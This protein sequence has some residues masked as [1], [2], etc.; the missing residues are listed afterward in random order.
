MDFILGLLKALFRFSI[1]ILAIT[2]IFMPIRYLS[3]DYP[4]DR[5]VWAVLNRAQVSAE[6][7]DM[8]Q[9]VSKAIHG[10]ENREGLFSRK[11]Q[12]EGHCAAIFKTPEN[13]L[14]EQYRVLKNIR[15]RLDRTNQMDKM[16]VEYATSVD[17]IRGT[18]RELP[19]LSCWIWHWD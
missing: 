1:V 13:S 14:A 2:L 8:H 10:L 16:S 15:S 6:S 11:S 19:Y 18:I 12:T 7:E 9:L 3:W 17:D 5:D 4:I